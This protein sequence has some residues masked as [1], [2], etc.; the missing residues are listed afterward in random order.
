MIKAATP[1]QKTRAPMTGTFLAASQ[2]PS[3]YGVAL[4][5]GICKGVAVAAGGAVASTMTGVN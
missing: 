2:P 1:P 3:W 5:L 4:G